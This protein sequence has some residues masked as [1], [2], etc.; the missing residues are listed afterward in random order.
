MKNSSLHCLQKA[1]I[2]VCVV[3]F[4]I[5]TNMPIAHPQNGTES[6]R[7]LELPRN[8]PTQPQAQLAR[9]LQYI[10]SLKGQESSS[11]D[12]TAQNAPTLSQLKQTMGPELKSI[13]DRLPPNMVND[14]MQDPAT[15][16]QVKDI[17]QQFSKDGRLPDFVNQPSQNQAQSGSQIRQPKQQSNS[18]NLPSRSAN[19][20]TQE[21]K[22][23]ETN[24]RHPNLPSNSSRNAQQRLADL[25]KKLRQK[26]SD[27]QLGGSSPNQQSQNR[28]TQVAPANDQFT[29]QPANQTSD[30]QPKNPTST[31]PLTDSQLTD[32][33]WEQRLQEL[34][35]KQRNSVGQQIEKNNPSN[36]QWDG[37]QTFPNGRFSTPRDS[38]NSTSPNGR[39]TI[40]DINAAAHRDAINSLDP[41]T[42]EHNRRSPSSNGPPKRL[43]ETSAAGSAVPS[44]SEF[45]EQMR[46]A[47][48]PNLS[49]LG[50][51]LPPAAKK[52]KSLLSEAIQQ[53]DSKELREQAKRAI[54]DKG[55]RKTLKEILRNAK[56]SAKQNAKSDGGLGGVIA[57]AAAA[58]GMEDTVWKT[59]SGM[60]DGLIEIAKN[61]K[62]KGGAA[63]G[64]SD[65]GSPNANQQSKS[66]KEKSTLIQLAKSASTAMKDFSKSS[67]IPSQDSATHSVLPS[68]K[69]AS[70][71][72]LGFLLLIAAVLVG[73]LF[74]RTRVTSTTETQTSE[75][76]LSTLL[77]QGIHS[78][79]D[80]IQ[81]FHQFALKPT[82][83]AQ[84]WWTHSRVVDNVIQQYPQHST[85]IQIL[86]ALYEQARYFPDETVF[87]DAQIQQAADAVRTV[88]VA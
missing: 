1:I 55:L 83:Q 11:Q 35:Q 45:L 74:A 82:H 64:S 59:L 27:S 16:S 40:A 67:E 32:S 62:L 51:N 88:S 68:L 14:A 8:S 78:K 66:S 43:D 73:R 3:G 81:A 37:A 9:L 25:L 31:A 47:P 10:Q 70:T 75:Q 84:H 42:V 26:Q 24:P 18:D 77:K 4:A 36:T 54:Q 7:R 21:V 65:T 50:V 87:T 46:D 48:T 39:P 20:N 44:M 15:R 49:D 41:K 29:P 52:P 34:I 13:F 71:W 60:G 22:P 69:N 38:Q 79:K 23:A 80:V 5:T 30:R 19:Q 57:D 12:P 58:T 85:R 28:N 6:H 76:V 17:L 53:M 61:T 56:Q 86:A 63:N 72:G 2:S 33:Q